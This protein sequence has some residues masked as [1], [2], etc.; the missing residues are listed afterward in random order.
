MR[1]VVYA[2]T[3]KGTLRPIDDAGAKVEAEGRGSV[4]AML[5]E[6]ALPAGLGVEPRF[7]STLEMKR[8]GTF[9]EFGT[10]D[11]GNGDALRF[12]E[13][14]PGHLAP[15]PDG[16]QSGAIDWK[17]DSGSGAFATATGYITSNFNLGEEGDFLDHQVVSIVLQ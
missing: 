1:R 2:A 7:Q 8:D 5:N 11:F 10:I 12:S 15:A 9:G 3:F 6:T 14:A 17:I 13:I 4:E 16:R